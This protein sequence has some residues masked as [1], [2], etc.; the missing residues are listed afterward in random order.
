M[1]KLQNIMF[2]QVQTS[3][4]LKQ[5]CDSAISYQKNSHQRAVY[6]S[7]QSLELLKEFDTQ[8]PEHMGDGEAILDLLAKQG[9][10]NTVRYSNGRYY[11]FVNGSALPIGLAAKWLAD[12]WDQNAALFV[13]SPI[14]AKL[15]SICQ[16]WLQQL[17]GLPTNT[18]AGFVGGTSIASL[19][20]IAAARY[21]QLSH[22]GWDITQQGLF[23][24]PALRIILGRQTH[25]SVVKGLNILGFG[26]QQIEWVDC[27]QQGRIKVESIPP[28]D[29]SCIIVLQA[30]NVCSGAF[31]DFHTI[32]PKA[33]AAKAWV[34]VDG[35]FGLWAGASQ[36]FATLTKSMHLAD[37]WSVDGHKTLNTPYDCGVIL[38]ADA[39]ALTQAMQQQG[40]YIQTSESRDNMMF[41]P[42]MSRRARGIELWACLAYLGKS[43]IAELVDLLHQ[44]AVYFAKQAE[45]A[46]FKV[47][48][49]V[50]F[51]QVI[52][53][54]GSDESTQN[55]LKSIQNSGVSWCGGATWMGQ[56]V[57]RISICSWAT[58]QSEIDKSISIF[59]NCLAEYNQPM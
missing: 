35:A 26:Q 41:T 57:I 56:Q 55:I 49:E 12:V 22:L 30:G 23:A 7:Q 24:A 44:H 8:L 19:C 21:R 28:L 42:D 43:G 47:L 6:P 39:S 51:N 9:E 53:S 38:C 4:L 18:V 17:F 34:H 32:I 48:N 50:V 16:Q 59:S 10:L 37:S 20:G 3:T 29:K 36:R 2:E 40:S 5:A 46:G 13:T 31:D 45:I 52:L 1:S 14:A 33:K 25:S 11:G 58:T 27:D 15:E 54:A